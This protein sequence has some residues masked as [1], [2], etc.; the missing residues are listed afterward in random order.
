MKTKKLCVIIT[1]KMNNIITS[2]IDSNLLDS[3]AEELIIFTCEC[4]C[5]YSDVKYT[6]FNTHLTT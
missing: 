4:D 1:K 3:F 2:D 6:H 5:S